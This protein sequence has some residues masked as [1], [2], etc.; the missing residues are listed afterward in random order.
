MPVTF[1]KAD[2]DIVDIVAEIMREHHRH[3]VIEDVRVGV[4]AAICTTG[5]A[6]K[7]HGHPAYATMKVVSLKDRLSKRYD[8]ELVL[9]A[10]LFERLRPSQQCA[11]I[12]HE[13][14]F[15][16]LVLDPKGN[17]VRDDLGRPKLRTVPGDWG[18]VD[19]FTAVVKRWGLSSL[20][21]RHSQAVDKRILAAIDEARSEAEL[22]AK[23]ELEEP[24]T[25]PE[26]VEVPEVDPTE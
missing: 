17:V 20:E 14:S 7:A 10:D 8:A 12:D 11:L 1:Q 21:Y 3:L 6:V 22:A 19:G 5:P 13:L 4:I 18:G 15:L 25:E 23:S 2:P 9:D 16:R 24:V 26:K